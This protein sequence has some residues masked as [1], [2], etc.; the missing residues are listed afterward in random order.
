MSLRQGFAR[1]SSS[2]RSPCPPTHAP[3]PCPPG[4]RQLPFL[5][6]SSSPSAE[7]VVTAATNAVVLVARSSPRPE[8]RLLNPTH[9]LLAEGAEEAAKA[10]AKALRLRKT[11]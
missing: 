4:P 1:V 3:L 2:Q 7:A 10:K 6:L 9:R 11:R 5:T 8:L